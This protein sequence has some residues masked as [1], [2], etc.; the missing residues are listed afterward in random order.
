MYKYM[1]NRKNDGVGETSL[2]DHIILLH[3]ALL[4]R[5]A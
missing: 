2:R 1:V 3:D 5:G 4:A